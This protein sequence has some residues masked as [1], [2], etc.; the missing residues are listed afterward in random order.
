MEIINLITFAGCTLLVAILSFILTKNDDHDSNV[1]Y[2][3]GGR[4]L[5]GG[6]IAGSLMLT[7]LST[8]QLVGLN[9]VS[10]LE[11]MVC[12]AWETLAGLA[13]VVMALVFLP[14]YLKSG[15]TTI[16]QFM[17]ERF[18]HTTRTIATFLFLSGYAI[19]LL[20]MVLYSG[21]LAF[22][23]MFDLPHTLG[24][25]HTASVWLCVWAIGIAGSLYA[26]IGGLRTVA[27]SDTINGIGL[28]I[29]GLAIPFFGVLYLGEGSFAAGISA[30]KNNHPELLNSVGR[31]DQ[32][33]PFGTLFTGMV[34]VQLFYWC[35]NQQIIQ[36]TFGAKN[37]VEGQK[38]VL[39]AGFLKTLG[40]LILVVPGMIAFHIF[41]NTL[42]RPDMAYGMLVK[43][44][45]PGWLVGFFAAVLAG[46]I[47]SSFNSG[48]N[49]ACTLYGLGVYK[50]IIKKE[51]NEHQT[52]KSGKIFGIFLAIFA[53]STAPLIANAPE[54][55]FGYL[56]TVNGAYAIPI[57]S[58]ILVGFFAR[59]VPPIAAKIGLITGVV[60][61]SAT[62]IYMKPN[63]HYLH[64]MGFFFVFNIV[65][66][67]VIGFFVKRETAWVHQHSGDVDLT[68]WKHAK[69]AAL[70]IVVVVLISYISFSPLFI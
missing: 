20:P 12:I 34:L 18:D 30:L 64:L 9:G 32:S 36:R 17:E 28:I 22:T 57:F 45:L 5:T 27:I 50:G 54:G 55:L 4:R 69:L 66:M 39:L 51:A 44:V 65:L 61:Y 16:P 60:F 35:G 8:E 15:I 40:P 67:L 23:G 52:V 14:R 41:G 25:S 56:Q 29:G 6:V 31:A 2:F 48:L 24:I 1:G 38:G 47:L 70:I 53:M 63:I 58:V 46:A 42:E 21:A 33:V 13:L 26:I 10:Y 11:G 49:S 43:E 62:A 37:L 68:P 59:R 19:V 3:L 7:N